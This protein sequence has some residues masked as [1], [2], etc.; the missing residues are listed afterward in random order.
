[1]DYKKLLQA[2]SS[3]SLDKA[4]LGVIKGILD[5][6]HYQNTLD[7]YTWHLHAKT[8]ELKQVMIAYEEL[9]EQ[10]K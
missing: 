5:E 2:C 10:T 6:T 9:H 4:T 7:D 1:M 3:E 8:N